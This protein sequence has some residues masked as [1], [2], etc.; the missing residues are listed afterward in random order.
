[1]SL[2]EWLDL[3]EVCVPQLPVCLVVIVLKPLAASAMK[4]QRYRLIRRG[5]NS[6]TQDNSYQLALIRTHEPIHACRLR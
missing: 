2:Q 6:L 4:P 1:M 5:S 3:P